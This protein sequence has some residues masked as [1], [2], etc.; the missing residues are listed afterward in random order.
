MRKYIRVLIVGSD[1]SV[2]GG[3]TSVIDRFLNYNWN[4]IKVELLPTYIEGNSIKKIVFFLKG[5]LKYIKRLIK[6][7]F[8]I[9]HIHMSYKGSFFRKYLIVKLS[10]LFKKKVI[11]HLHGSEFEVFYDNSNLKI[12]NMIRN[13]LE[14]VDSVIV[15]GESWEKI[16]RRIA[17]N[18]NIDIFKNAVNV[19][20][21]KV[22]WNDE[23]INILFLGVLIKRKGI[24]ELI[25]AIN[26]L[27][28]SGVI[29]DKKLN[30]LIGGTGLEE[31]IIKNKIKE[32]DLE[33]CIKMVGW[34]SGKL[35][36]KLLE[37]S[38]VFIL[39]SYNEGLPMAILEAMSYG[40]PVIAT[41][42]GSISEVLKNDETGFLIEPKSSEI[43]NAI[44][45][46]IYSK[47]VWNYQSN[48]CKKKIQEEF[49]ENR[50]FYNMR[51][52]YYSYINM[53]IND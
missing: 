26:E 42:V 24:Y 31:D 12:K 17:P 53:E 7:D 43:I 29:R 33:Y 20:D 11:L 49:N 25:E 30:F 9:A 51:K 44:M 28:K 45:K 18:A 6:N 1:S 48:E 23:K 32:Y 8:D 40:I 4:G 36:E 3:I 52:K 5:V 50:Y 38:Q 47:K 35:K 21:Y 22:Q 15:L 19:P 16:V 39:P 10:K 41:N 13:L 37:K 34:V 14:N 46:I 2:K 27:H